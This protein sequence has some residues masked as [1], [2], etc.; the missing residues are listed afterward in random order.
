MY[1]TI[2]VPR[3][4]VLP[5]RHLRFHLSGQEATLLHFPESKSADLGTRGAW[6]S[7]HYSC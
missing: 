6:H 7:V 1:S 2:G 3:T 4:M 5:C